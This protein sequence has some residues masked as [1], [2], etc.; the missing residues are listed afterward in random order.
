MSDIAT[1]APPDFDAIETTAVEVAPSVSLLSGHG[2][3]TD[4]ITNVPC[5]FC[6]R[7][8]GMPPQGWRLRGSHE[9][10]EHREQWEAEKAKPKPARAK[11]ASRGKAA[12]THGSTA[13][14]SKPPKREDASELLTLGVTGISNLVARMPRDFADPVS[15]VL[16]FEASIA[17]PEIDAA[18]AGT[19]VDRVAVQPV[20]AGWE[21]L[22]RVGP[23]VMTPILVGLLAEGIGPQPVLLAM[24]RA[25]LEP[26]LPQ[27]LRQLVAD[28]KKAEALK[29]TAAQLAEMDP[30]FAE[31]FGADA[32]PIE[33]MIRTIFPQP[34]SDDNGAE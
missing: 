14:S 7:T 15:R 6:D 16:A 23:L 11:A 13:T 20:V 9:K 24:L 1:F 25:S 21:R 26:M 5:R 10:K 30:A 19:V 12:T 28:F 22:E 4:K 33:A 3:V 27:L 31:I 17:G 29:E 8:F 34:K 18:V 2:S 32:D